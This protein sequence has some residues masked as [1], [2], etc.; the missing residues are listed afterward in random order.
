[1]AEN[2]ITTLKSFCRKNGYQCKVDGSFFYIKTTNDHFKVNI[3]DLMTCSK[4]IH[5]YHENQGI[6]WHRQGRKTWEIKEL[7]KHIWE[8]D[9]LLSVHSGRY[10][11]I[12]PK[13]RE[14]GVQYGYQFD[15]GNDFVS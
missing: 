12:V 11:V 3:R 10:K 2:Y 4:T 13:N 7:Q 15:D 9:G 8:H 14:R 5:L 6:G 1:M